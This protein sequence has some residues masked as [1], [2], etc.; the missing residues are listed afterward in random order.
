M[1]KAEVGI[2]ESDETRPTTSLVSWLSILACP[3]AYGRQAAAGNVECQTLLFYLDCLI[4][5]I[6]KNHIGGTQGLF[7]VPHMWLKKRT[8]LLLANPPAYG[9]Q[10][11]V[12]N[13]ECPMPIEEYRKKIVQCT[14]YQVR[15][16]DFNQALNS[17]YLVH[18][19]PAAG[20]YLV[21]RTI[22]L[23]DTSYLLL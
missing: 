3:P 1:S 17:H 4:Q 21:L 16:R 23:L 2:C 6:Q 10:A 13:I 9:R 20:W 15:S 18:C 19:L 8:S 22:L 5:K 14:M 7:Y 12:V 11:T